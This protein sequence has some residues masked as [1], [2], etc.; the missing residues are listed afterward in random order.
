MDIEERLSRMRRYCF[1]SHCYSFLIITFLLLSQ[2]VAAQSP[3]CFGCAGSQ[4]VYEVESGDFHYSFLVS[5]KEKSASKITFDW[6]MT[7]QDDNQG[8][9]TMS[10]EA[11]ESAE[12]L[13][14]FYEKGSNRTVSDATAL[15]LSRKS[16]RALKSGQ[17]VKL[18]PGDAIVGFQRDNSYEGRRRLKALSTKYNLDPNVNTILAQG[19]GGK[20][21]IFLDDE[22]NPLII[23][24][25]VG[26]KL[27]MEGLF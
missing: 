24:M 7:I 16:Y 25:F 13:F 9:L 17:V 22:S 11:L 18:N 1:M 23:E 21:I 20:Y 14:S 19:K 12:Q 10:Q 6:L 26:F 27:T 5:V 2:L 4:M 3:T 15:W 8:T